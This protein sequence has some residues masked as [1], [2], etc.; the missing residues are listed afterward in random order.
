MRRIQS[1]RSIAIV[2]IAIVSAFGTIAAHASCDED[3]PSV[4]ASLTEAVHADDLPPEVASLVQDL[5]LQLIPQQFDDEEGWG[6]QVRVQSGL[7]VDWDDGRLETRRRWKQVNHGSWVRASGTLV[8]PEESFRLT[9]TREVPNGPADTDHEQAT[10]EA[11]PVRFD[12]RASARLR[13]TGRQQQWNHG[14]RL[15]SLSADAIADVTL[16]VVLDVETTVEPVDGELA[17]LVRPQV[18]TAD[19]RL[20]SLDVRRISHFKGAAVRESTA[21]LEKLIQNRVRQESRDLAPRIQKALDRHRNRLMLPLGIGD[22][23]HG[24]S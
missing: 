6:D 2:A 20:D 14:W 3:V 8:N 4:P 13:V 10:A 5:A 11:K 22:W 15:W 17:V 21:W 7:D 23:L 12:I 24:K 19:V 9:L 18:I 16:H 1:P